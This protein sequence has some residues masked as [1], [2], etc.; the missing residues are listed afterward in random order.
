MTAVQGQRGKQR[1]SGA[2]CGAPH[3]RRR[4]FRGVGNHS[5]NRL[6]ARAAIHSRRT[7]DRPPAP[8]ITG[9]KKKNFIGRHDWAKP[10]PSLRGS[11]ASHIALAQFVNAG[12]RKLNGYKNEKSYWWPPKNFPREIFQPVPW[13]ERTIPTAKSRRPGPRLV[14]RSRPRGPSLDSSTARRI[15][16]NF[17]PPSLTPWRNTNV[18]RP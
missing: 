1:P 6:A 9:E 16:A 3:S 12:Q 5:R 18:A 14:A 8:R 13:K 11:T 15:S 17:G 10:M 7:Q 4:A 2:A